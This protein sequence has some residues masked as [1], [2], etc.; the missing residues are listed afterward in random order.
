MADRDPDLLFV[1]D[2]AYRIGVSHDAVR[3]MIRREVLPAPA[4]LGRRLVWRR[5][6]IDRWLDEK[7]S[8]GTTP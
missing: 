6:D 5:S 7:F 1:P 3:S 4:K 2:L 8:G